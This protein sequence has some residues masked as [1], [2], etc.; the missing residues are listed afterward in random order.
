MTTRGET[1]DA[2]TE[3]H[4]IVEAAVR[5][6]RRA[7]VLD[8]Y[9]GPA[10]VLDR[11]PARVRVRIGEVTTE[12]TLALAFPYEPSPEDVVLVVARRGEAYVI[13]L[14]QGRGK[15]ALSIPGDVEVHAVDGVLSLRGDRGVRVNGPEVEVVAQKKIRLVAETALEAFGSLTRKVRGLFTSQVAQ[16]MSTVEGAS[17]DVAKSAT[18]VTEETMTINGKKINLG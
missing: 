1:M 8:D 13:G 5:V 17:V 12:A 11:G 14:L 4:S 2:S 16:R 9:L 3:E 6:A 7:E 18:I 15:V 10:E